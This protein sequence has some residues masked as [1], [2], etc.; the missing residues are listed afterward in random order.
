[1]EKEM[2]KTNDIKNK[3]YY[4]TFR[5]DGRFV[6]KVEATNLENAKKIALE[7]YYDAD[8]GVLECVDS[9]IVTVEDESGNFIYEK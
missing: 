2:N 7:H 4:V 6:T 9:E 1:M 5:I 3:E 8:F